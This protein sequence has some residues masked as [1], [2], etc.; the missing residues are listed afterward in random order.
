MESGKEQKEIFIRCRERILKRL[1]PGKEL[2][3][4]DVL[5]E[6]D[7]VLLQ[8]GKESFL[9]I[10]EREYLRKALFDSLRGM[11]ILQELLDDPSV[12]EI[13]V[14]GPS[15]IFLEKQGRLVRWNKQFSSEERLETLIHQIAAGVNRVINEQSPIVDARLKDGSRVHA[16]L[17]PA[18][19]D[20]PILT[21][22][23]FGKKPLTLEEMTR[24]GTLSREAA[25]F[26]TKLV[27]EGYNLFVSGGTGSGKTTLLNALAMKIPA[28][29][30]V[31]TIEDD[32]ELNL[33]RTENLVR[34]EARNPDAEGNLEI[35]IR[36]L[37]RASLRMRPDRI[38]VGEVRD[39][40]A[41]DM[42]Q[43]MLTGH[44][45]CF[46]TGHADSGAD[47]IKR[48]ETM[49]LDSKMTVEAVRRQIASAVDVLIH[50]ERF[51]NGSR[52][53]TEITEVLGYE[54]DTGRVKLAPLYRWKTEGGKEGLIRCGEL[55][56]VRK[57]KQGTP[58]APP[59]G[60][61]V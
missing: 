51:R 27:R 17:P 22:R 18:S 36:D 11:D 60:P 10:R 31:I 33:S 55:T 42:L 35:S 12:T 40:A 21:I 2:S 56:N 54:E 43:A 20:G 57:I 53:V 34:L 47:M 59:K 4:A 8:A 3:D 46:S 16:V 37:I 7:S 61:G 32:A 58:P 30:R 44:R 25:G 28:G 5:Q 13:M 24:I 45:G 29:E 41:L 48:L 14:N 23:K 6:I 19:V 52:H 38:I 39:A 26:L 49:A 9:S 15:R 50:L 1:D